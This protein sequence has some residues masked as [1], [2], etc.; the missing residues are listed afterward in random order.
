[1]RTAPPA[2]SSCPSPPR[3]T[4]TRA[5]LPRWPRAARGS[6]RARASPSRPPHPAHRPQLAPAGAGAGLRVVAD[7]AAADPADDR[8]G[9]LSGPLDHR[10][11]RLVVEIVAGGEA[12]QAV[13]FRLRP[14]EPARPTLAGEGTVQA[15]QRLDA[16]QIAQHE[17]VQRDLQLQL[18]LDLLCRVGARARLVVLD[19][20]AR[21]E[22]VDIDPVDLPR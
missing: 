4:R 10:P 20:A 14:Q 16:D 15:S 2:P 22:G 6:G 17:H 18:G 5:R 8:A 3:P 1:G 19:D 13:V 7:V 9:V 21:T 12:G 11:E